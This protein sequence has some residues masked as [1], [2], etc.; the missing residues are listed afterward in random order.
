MGTPAKNEDLHGSA[1]DEANAALLLIDVINDFEFEGGEA[2]F[3]HA[4]PMAR[5]IA[6]LKKRARRA[7]IPSI[8]IND[9]F[10]KWQSDFQKLISHC[11]KAGTRGRPVAELLKP[12]EDDY[13]VLKPKHSGFFSTTLDTL[14]NYLKVRTLI[15]TG[16]A[17]DICVLFTASDAF[18]RDFHLIVPG[19]CVAS[20]DPQQNRAALQQ[21]KRVLKADIS[22]STEL[23]LENL[24]SKMP[25]E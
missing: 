23:D 12:D 19:D 10:G 11:L 8:Y 13:F 24:N 14:L 17:G 6:E 3:E 20:N 15:I 18:M 4:L 9:N 1:P 21:M 5:R 16:V 22:P 7:G 2:L 25:S